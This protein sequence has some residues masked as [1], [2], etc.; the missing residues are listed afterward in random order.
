VVILLM[1]AAAL[2]LAGWLPNWP[3]LM[4]A[5]T[6]MVLAVRWFLPRRLDPL[7]QACPY[8]LLI[9]LDLVSLFFFI[10]PQLAA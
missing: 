10:V 9:S 3:L 1:V 5:V 2:R 6:A 7:V 8:L 4:V